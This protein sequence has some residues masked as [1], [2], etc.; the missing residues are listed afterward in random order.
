[1]LYLV[2]FYISSVCLLWIL[3][4]PLRPTTA[5]HFHQLALKLKKLLR[6][7]VASTVVVFAALSYYAQ[8][9][10]LLCWCLYSIVTENRPERDIQL[11]YLGASVCLV[12]ALILH[13][14]SIVRAEYLRLVAWSPIKSA[15]TISGLA[16]LGLAT[17][18]IKAAV[19]VLS[20]F[21][22]YLIAAR[23]FDHVAQVNFET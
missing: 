18:D 2:L 11:I 8:H 22:F 16:G 3:E 1:M 23:T 4:E 17:A 20:A 15:A 19:L 5:T 7:K 21:T 14:L 10:I 13:A 6:K 12:S 9:S